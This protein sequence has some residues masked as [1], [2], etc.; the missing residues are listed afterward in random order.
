MSKKKIK[1]EAVTHWVPADRDQVN[2]AIAEMG[3]LQRERV[4]IEAA[5]N[6]KLAAVKAR[7]EALAKPKGDR[8]AELALGVKLWC[9][10]NR[11]TLT[12]DGRVKF[13]EFATGV[14]KWRLTPWAVSL[15]NVAEVLAL[16]KA[17]GLTQY[18]RTKEEIDKEALLADRES[19]GDSI[20]GVRIGQKE[21]FSIEPAATKIEEVQG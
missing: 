18:I 6:D 11:A 1:A 3:T 12:K 17:K 15:K 21:E 14:V 8:I 4:R 13:H 20:K 19:L 5:M 16:L 2:E 9:E 10:A 7:Y